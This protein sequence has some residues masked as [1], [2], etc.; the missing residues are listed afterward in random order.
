M[1]KSKAQCTMFVHAGGILPVAADQMFALGA[2]FGKVFPGIAEL[3]RT[4]H[5]PERHPTGACWRPE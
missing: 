3:A 5:T 1:N 4:L 2:Y